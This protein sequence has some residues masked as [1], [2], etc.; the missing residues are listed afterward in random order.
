MAIKQITAVQAMEE[1]TH[2][3]VVMES[4]SEVQGAWLALVDTEA[5]RVLAC[6][7]KGECQFAALFAKK[8]SAQ[9][10]GLNVDVMELNP[11]NA[12]VVRR[13]L[14]WTA[15]QAQNGK[16][17]SVAF[18]DWLGAA[19]AYAAPQFKLRQARPVLVDYAASNADILKRNFLEAVDTATWGV[20]E[21]GYKE[22]YGANAAGLTMEEEIVKALLYGYSMIGFDCSD[23]IDTKIEALNADEVAGKYNQLPE[24]FRNAM[25]GSYLEA[26]FKAGDTIV[27]FEPEVLQRIVLEFG[28]AI[29]HIQYIYNTYL[30]NT[31]WDIDFEL[32][33]AKPDKLM[34][35]QELYL[36]SNELQRN[37]IKMASMELDAAKAAADP[38]GMKVYG[39]IAATF[40]YRLSLFNAD[41]YAAELGAL[42]KALKGQVCFKAGNL[43]WLA[44]LNVI[45]AQDEA[46]VGEMQAF[47]GLPEL[48]AT[49]ILPADETSCA[50][51]LAY[52]KLLNPEEGFAAKIKAVLAANTAAYKV[53]VEKAVAAVLKEL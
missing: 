4:V 46:L 25:K 22:G 10:G 21:L 44:A 28:E 26:D 3:K 7:Y 48:T 51:A 11:N 39:E 35:P 5:G 17:I 50:W 13:Y 12:A 38:E 34:T 49:K 14:K 16:G 45:K 30:K 42:A 24:E 18:S 8:E 2:G 53:E 19:A 47:A 41:L 52:K 29:M 23:K 33:L 9:S 32:R 40:G 27:H 1:I 20:L 6:A 43:L 37:G 31:P 15:P 36:I